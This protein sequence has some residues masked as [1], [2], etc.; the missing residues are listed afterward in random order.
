MAS[1]FTKWLRGNLKSK[2][3]RLALIQAAAAVLALPVI[4]PAGA[5]L[6]IGKSVVDIALRNATDESIEDKARR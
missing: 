1:P 4:T 3:V 6:V 2:T 5:A